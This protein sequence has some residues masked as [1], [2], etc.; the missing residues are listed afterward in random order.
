MSMYSKINQLT[1]E[2]KLVR[3]SL[4]CPNCGA[5][6]GD[7]SGKEKFKCEWCRQTFA[8]TEINKSSS[9]DISWKKLQ[10]IAKL[11]LEMMNATMQSRNDILYDPKKF[12]PRNDAT[13]ALYEFLQYGPPTR[14]LFI[15]LGEAGFGKTWLMSN[16]ANTLSDQGHVVFYICLRDGID[17]FFNINFLSN[18]IQALIH[19]QRIQIP[20]DD[21]K[22]II[23]IM[24]GYDE[25]G[26]EDDKKALLIQFLD[27]IRKNPN[28]VMILTSRA[29]DWYN[30]MIA[31][32]QHN[33]I[34]RLLWTT[35]STNTNISFQLMSYTKE[36][37]NNAIQKY[38]L[39]KIQEWPQEIQELA[40][41]PLWIRIISEWYHEHHDTLPKSITRDIYDKYFQRMG[42]DNQHL[43]TLAEISTRLLKNYNNLDENI[44]LTKKLNLDHQ[45]IN[46]LNSCGILHYQQHLYTPSIRLSTP[47][48][49]WFGIVFQCY[50]L[51]IDDEKQDLLQTL[52]AIKK[53]PNDKDKNAI[54]TLL[55]E[56]DIPLP[57]TDDQVKIDEFKQLVADV[58]NHIIQRSW[59]NARTNANQ[60]LNL[61]IEINNNDL[62]KTAEDLLQE[63]T[64]KENLEK[65]FN[66]AITNA[67]QQLK[68]KNHGTARS[69]ANTASDLANQ[70]AD[71]KLVKTAGDLLSRITMLENLEAN[72]RQ[73]MDAAE[74]L[75][76]AG[77]YQAAI[78][79]LSEALATARTA[80]WNAEV[81]AIESKIAELKKSTGKIWY[82]DY[83]EL[84]AAEHEAMLDIEKLLGE[85]IPKV[86]KVEWNTFGFVEKDWHIVQLGLYNKGLTSL[87]RRRKACTRNAEKGSSLGRRMVT[88]RTPAQKTS[89]PKHA[90]QRTKTVTSTTA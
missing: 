78:D 27:F 11:H 62:T 80:G 49:G 8:V 18:M 45:T 29:F 48:F 67:K 50:Q 35:P 24:D 31:K 4:Q 30:C 82:H 7:L 66:D 44:I 2:I 68:S 54:T 90:W 72:Y 26:I 38:Q 46:A 25:I 70:L 22:P 23:W 69:F 64:T 60:A 14:K 81:K 19:L 9:E 16:W 39:P 12:I 20:D 55:D 42:L 43:I 33:A 73:A 40:R 59:A 34:Q 57:T 5:V 77:N 51:Y 89:A 79:K 56:F 63:I 13:D 37:S 36:E 74:N 47:I 87:V 3:R 21:D 32:N 17:A 76:N 84:I 58:K 85:P 65:K 52:D 75:I 10:K 61:A 28:H 71:P 83:C 6:T 1:K 53:L 41:F 15:L 86:S 88:T